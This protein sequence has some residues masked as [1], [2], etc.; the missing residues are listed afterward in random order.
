MHDICER[1]DL[2]PAGSLSHIQDCMNTAPVHLIK[3]HIM[4][5]HPQFEM[6]SNTVSKADSYDVELHRL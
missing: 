4:Q 5:D 2:V 3:A 6:K 1:A